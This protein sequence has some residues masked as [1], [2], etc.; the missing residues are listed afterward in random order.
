M[1][2]FEKGETVVVDIS[3]PLYSKAEYALYWDG[4]HYV[5]DDLYLEDGSIKRMLVPYDDDK[6]EA[7][8]KEK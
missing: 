7:L 8:E 4:Q 1:K 5:Y 6:I 3:T 2:K